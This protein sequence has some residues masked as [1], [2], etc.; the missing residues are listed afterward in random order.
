MEKVSHEK[1]TSFFH[2]RHMLQRHYKD[3]TYQLQINSNNVAESEWD[4]KMVRM[5]HSCDAGEYS[6]ITVYGNPCGST[7]KYDG[8]SGEE[9]MLGNIYTMSHQVDWSEPG[10]P[11]LF[12]REI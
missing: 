9:F 8:Q 5:L 3:E 7:D 1:S 2:A 11:T 10:Q 4:I 12:W 6:V